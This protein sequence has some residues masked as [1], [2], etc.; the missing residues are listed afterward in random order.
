MTP[1]RGHQKREWLGWEWDTA[2]W[3]R[4]VIN[5]SLLH[6]FPLKY[7][8]RS[9]ICRV[10]HSCNRPEVAVVHL[11]VQAMFP[12]I[13]LVLQEDM[14][15]NSGRVD[16]ASGSG[17]SVESPSGSFPEG[18][19]VEVLEIVQSGQDFDESDPSVHGSRRLHSHNPLAR[20]LSASPN[21][22]SSQSPGDVLVSL[23]EYSSSDEETLEPA[24]NTFTHTQGTDLIP[25]SADAVPLSSSRSVEA[26]SA[27]GSLE[28]GGV[29]TPRMHAVSA[30]TEDLPSSLVPQG[31][32]HD[33]GSASPAG[34]I[35]EWTEPQRESVAGNR[36]H[37]S[38]EPVSESLDILSND[39]ILDTREEVRDGEDDSDLV[40]DRV[41]AIRNLWDRQPVPQVDAALQWVQELQKRLEDAKLCQ[42]NLL[43][44]ASEL[45]D[46]LL[47]APCHPCEGSPENVETLG[48]E[49]NLLMQRRQGA[50]LHVIYASIGLLS[51]PPQIERVCDL[52]CRLLFPV[53]CYK[54]TCYTF[55]VP[56]YLWM[57]KK[58]AWRRRCKQ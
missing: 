47:L 19:H 56:W 11:L 27:A 35:H 4:Y 1:R 10:C 45:K 23:V 16:S 44:A 6:A 25:S 39:I 24:P 15:M 14:A 43:D 20:R 33:D 17:L 7:L 36:E 46:S 48:H 8:V 3:K 57:R 38:E 49:R 2:P 21:E 52:K 40:G 51:T 13:S 22:A 30:C 42:E 50:P 41:C 32:S 9:S 29:K 58:R 37:A 31:P 54:E 53:Q 34:E 5:I 18:L 55:S 26:V 28:C 12:T